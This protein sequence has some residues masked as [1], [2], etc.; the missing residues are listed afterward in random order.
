M[1]I[2]AKNCRILAAQHYRII[3]LHRGYTSFFTLLSVSLD[4]LFFNPKRD[5]KTPCTKPAH[6]SMWTKL[7]LQREYQ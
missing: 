7:D 5:A 2:K 3:A 4:A 6:A 1:S